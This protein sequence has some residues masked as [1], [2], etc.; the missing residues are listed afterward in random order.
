MREIINDPYFLFAAFMLTVLLTIL[1][2][3]GS[4]SLWQKCQRWRAKRHASQRE[5]QR[6]KEHG[7]AITFVAHGT[8]HGL[9]CEGSSSGHGISAVS[10]GSSYGEKL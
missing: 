10:T 9:R 3:E 6:V 7:A 5:A 4:K 2:T 1:A 8:G